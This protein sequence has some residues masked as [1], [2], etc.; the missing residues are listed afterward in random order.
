MFE[1][2]TLDF[3]LTPQ[4]EKIS[5]WC[6]FLELFSDMQVLHVQGH[7]PCWKAGERWRAKNDL[8][9]FLLLLLLL[10]LKL[11]LNEDLLLPYIIIWRESI[12]VLVLPGLIFSF[13]NVTERDMDIANRREDSLSTWLVDVLIETRVEI[14]SLSVLTELKLEEMCK[15]RFLWK[16]SSL[17]YTSIF[18]KSSYLRNQHFLNLNVKIRH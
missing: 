8:S 18:K 12:F 1:C 5:R 3:V 9:N 13:E 7:G 11:I 15:N 14:Y 4:Y 16:N 6:I 10:K 17:Y 2:L